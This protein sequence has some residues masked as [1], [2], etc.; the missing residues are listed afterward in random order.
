VLG[1]FGDKGIGQRRSRENTSMA[2][3]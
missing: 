1:L 3:Y 2:F